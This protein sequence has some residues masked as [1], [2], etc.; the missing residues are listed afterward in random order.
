MSHPTRITYAGDTT[1]GNAQAVVLF[2]SRTAFAPGSMHL[3]GQSWFTYTVGNTEAGGA[4]SLIGQSIPDGG[5]VL[6]TFYD[7]G[8]QAADTVIQ[9]DVYIGGMKDVVFTYTNG[10]T[11]GT[12]TVNLSLSCTRGG[13]RSDGSMR[14]NETT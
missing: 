4:A 5:T 6:E 10:A 8:L 12:I 1:L 9:D 14:V 3:L 2:D 11:P 7:S 13:A